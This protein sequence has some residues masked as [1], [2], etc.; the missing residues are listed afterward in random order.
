MK[1][2]ILFIL[3]FNFVS[4]NNSTYLSSQEK[5]ISKS[6]KT[7]VKKNT[8]SKVKEDA[9]SR[10]FKK[11]KKKKETKDT[12]TKPSVL[13]QFIKTF[14]VLFLLLI[15]FWVFKKFITFKKE[16][17]FEEGQ[18]FNV[19]YEQNIKSGKS[20]QFVQLG[21]KILVLGISDAGIQLVT[22]IT[23]KHVIDKINI[24]IEK[25]KKS[26]KKDFL[27]E[28][29]TSIKGSIDI[30]KSKQKFKMNDDLT[31][32]NKQVNILRNNVSSNLKKMK[33][34]RKSIK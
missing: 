17:I 30:M 20:L 4:N 19:L 12:S 18:I 11:E 10:Y 16:N 27:T 3:L 26:V 34:N 8:Q 6:E 9:L 25:Q 5:K 2:I 7:S 24:D 13:W 15:I 1:K 14:F 23:E 33:E 21:N 31:N 29:M 32:E 22:E 28:L